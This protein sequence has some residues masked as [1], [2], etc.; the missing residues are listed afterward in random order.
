MTNE[1]IFE[2]AREGNLIK[3]GQVVAGADLGVTD[4]D[5]MTPLMHAAANNR[6]AV[7]GLLVGTDASVINAQDTRGRTAL[8]H[9][10]AAG[11]HKI[12]KMLLKR[13]ADASPTDSNGKTARDHAEAGGHAKSLKQL[14]KHG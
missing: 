1:Q 3:L 10:C 9:A 6:Y 11:G 14:S 7:A 13:G 8:M 12:V 5:G 4:A 2:H